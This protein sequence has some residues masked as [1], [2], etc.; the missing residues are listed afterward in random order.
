MCGISGILNFSAPGIPSEELLCKMVSVLH[1]RGPDETGIYLDPNVGLGHSRL[2]IIGL[3]DGTQPISNEDETLWIVFN[4]E[5]FNYIELRADLI[6][7]GHQFKTNTDTEVIL[8]LY[9]DHG[10]DCL[11]ELNGQFAFA[12]WN[13]VDK[14]LFL[15]RD[16]VGIRPLF[17][18]FLKGRFL[19]ASEIKALFLDPSIPRAIDLESLQQIFT[20][21]A[22]IGSRTV[23]QG[24]QQLSPGH[25]QIIRCGE[26]PGRPQPYWSIPYYPVDQQWQGSKGDA[27]EEL[28]FLLKDSVRI[29]LR[30][31]VPVGA[32][33]SGGLDSSILT[34]I[35]A[36][37]FNNRLKTFSLGFEE[38]AYDEAGYQ[39]EM[40]NYLGTDHQQITVSNQNVLERFADVVWHCEKPLLR[41]GPVPLFLLSGLVRDHQLKVVLTGEGADEVF[42]GYNIFKEAKVRNFWG[43][44]PESQMRPALVERL[45]PY[46][47]KNAGQSKSFLQKF[48]STDEQD[49]LDP[50]LSHRKRWQNTGKSTMF[51]NRSV[52]EELS[53]VDPIAELSARLP[54]DFSDRD[55]FSRTQWLEMDIFLSNY[56]LSSQGDRVAMS[57]NLEL[58]LPYLDKRLINF[59]AR[60]PAHWKMPGLKEKQLLKKAYRGEIPDSICNRPK[61]PYRAPTGP[62]FFNQTG[63]SL[64][65][66]VSFDQIK[67]AG[68]FNVIKVQN[69]FEKQCRRD[70]PQTSELEN[71]A[72]VGILS[73]QLIHENFIKCFHGRFVAPVVPDKV[74]RRVHLSAR[75]ATGL[76]S[77]RHLSFQL[78]IS[79]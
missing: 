79:S 67:G 63:D 62:V 18:T 1:H 32:Y 47:F 16:R 21:W 76:Y 8:H 38:E 34:S 19:F 30:A 15:A 50:L 71:M 74:V 26:K 29:R 59:A 53:G 40:A 4:G 11:R 72:V 12:I 48:F 22:P 65:D 77:G 31:D 17:T 23:F 56:L 28:R 41:T 64:H 51:F 44:C 10:A 14:E 69:L 61:Q 7:K 5:I 45:Y 43:R 58:R 57:H 78:E 20:C 35:I 6:K 27:L 36:K 13:R 25:Y 39:S 49:L 60:L 66:L 55:I 3:D 54:V 75:G 70:R 46:I 9:E 2:S 33:L 68:I 42:G 52:L 73:T 24:V 37:N